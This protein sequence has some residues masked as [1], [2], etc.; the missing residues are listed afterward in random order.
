M[1]VIPASNEVPQMHADE[2]SESEPDEG[3]DEEGGTVAVSAEAETGSRITAWYQAADNAAVG[4]AGTVVDSAAV[5]VHIRFFP[6]L[7][8]H[9]LSSACAPLLPPTCRVCRVR[10]FQVTSYPDSSLSS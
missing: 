10:I 5:A 4:I 7:F 6:S 8:S 3:E 1:Q 9:S 2:A